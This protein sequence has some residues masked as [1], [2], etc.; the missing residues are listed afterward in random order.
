MSEKQSAILAEY[1]NCQSILEN[2]TSI[3]YGILSS[4]IEIPLVKTLLK[5]IE[6]DSQKHATIMKG[7]SQSIKQPKGT[8]KNCSKNNP[9]LQTIDRLIKEAEKIETISLAD[10]K[11]LG[12]I[13]ITLES[14]MGEEYYSLVQM[15]TLER[16]TKIINQDYS[17]DLNN[18]KRIFLKIIEDEERHIEIL[19]TIKQMTTQKE[20]PNNTPLVRFQSPDS[21]FKPAISAV[22]EQ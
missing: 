14:Q 9:T 1:L 11:N 15:K 8:I 18:V 17:I 2:Q 5:E 12:G 13:F 7:V 6:V 21:W 20:P 19:E 3:L 16:M 22:Y 10:L 4:K